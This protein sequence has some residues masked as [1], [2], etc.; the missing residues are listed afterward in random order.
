MK[1]LLIVLFI[2]LFIYLIIHMCRESGDG[3]APVRSGKKTDKIMLILDYLMA[4]SDKDLYRLKNDIQD[5]KVAL[6]TRDKN[7]VIPVRSLSPSKPAAVGRREVLSGK[8]VLKK[9]KR[10]LRDF[11]NHNYRSSG[12]PFS[13]IR[14]IL[15][16]IALILI[17]LLMIL[18]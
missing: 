2:I 12:N 14:I 17:T 5:I 4:L 11:E 3:R 15:I 16:Q 13:K 1:T 10:D 9:I 6:D 18:Y 8:K 7:A